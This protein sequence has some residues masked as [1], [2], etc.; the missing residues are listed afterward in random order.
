MLNLNVYRIMLFKLVIIFGLLITFG[1]SGGGGGSGN[2]TGE[3]SPEASADQ[4][5]FDEL[6]APINSG[7]F[8]YG[9]LNDKGYYYNFY[10]ER[11]DRNVPQLINK[12][13]LAKDLD[14]NRSVLFLQ[15]EFD[16]HQRPVKII[17]PDAQGTMKIEYINDDTAKV[18]IIGE[19]GKQETLTVDHPFQ[20]PTQASLQASLDRGVISAA[21]CDNILSAAMDKSIDIHGNIKGCEGGPQ[22]GVEIVGGIPPKSYYADLHPINVFGQEPSDWNYYVTIDTE[23]HL[24]FDRWVTHCKCNISANILLTASGGNEVL[25]VVVA[26]GE[27][28]GNFIKDIRNGTISNTMQNTLGAVLDALVTGGTAE[29]LG[30]LVDF[31]ASGATLPCTKE[32]YELAKNTIENDYDAYC[33]FGSD[34]TKHK[35]FD[36]L[37]GEGPDF[38]WSGQCG[39][40]GDDYVV[41]YMDN[42]RCWDAPYVYATDR[43]RFNLEE[44]TCNIPGGGMNC[45]IKVKKVEMKG[46][47]NTLEE[48]QDWFCSQIASNWYHYWCN[49]RGPRIHLAGGE[50]YTLKIP[51]DLTDVPFLYP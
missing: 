50:I 6:E 13:V 8:L 15:I 20:L 9:F 10:G 36:P 40:N 27:G 49:S 21:I 24:D 26:A 32:R 37:T 42:V 33:D 16:E 44:D 12:L 35:V 47:F 51:C 17:L 1:C 19:N 30:Q 14:D 18:T 31:A 7:S 34:S 5:P 38:D 4:F 25:D 3:V 41:W 22:P 45:D 28:L 48:A 39:D 43:G 46:E 23:V 29:T 2:E 11:D